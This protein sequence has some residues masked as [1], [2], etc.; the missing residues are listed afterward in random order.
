MDG[1]TEVAG[2][3]P[4]DVDWAA[5][6]LEPNSPPNCSGFDS[7]DSPTVIF[8]SFQ[9]GQL[10]QVCDGVTADGFKAGASLMS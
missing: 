6:V 10:T 7:L 5:R 2:G 4:M 3:S 9:G 8:D 1:S